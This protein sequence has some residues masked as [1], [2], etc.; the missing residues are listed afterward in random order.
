MGGAA[1]LQHHIGKGSGGPLSHVVIT[2]MGRFKVETGIRHH[3]QSVV[4][5]TASK[6]KFRCWMERL[7]DEFIRQGQ[8]NGTACCDEEG[9][10]D[11]AS[12]YQETFVR[13]LTEIQQEHP[14]IILEDVNFG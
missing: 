12:Q 2:V 6:L 11:Q 14:D 1:V 10:F 5:E 3:L 8:R 7:N 4:D 13:F 9:N